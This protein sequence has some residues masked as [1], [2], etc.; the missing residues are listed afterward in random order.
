MVV[1]LC[2][3]L[4]A[5]DVNLVVRWFG[6][7]DCGCVCFDYRLVFAVY[8]GL[9]W[10]DGLLCEIVCVLVGHCCYLIV[11]FDSVFESWLLS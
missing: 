9:G 10:V 8:I 7:L 2:N 6:L 4:F 11:L 1:C 5:F 3:V